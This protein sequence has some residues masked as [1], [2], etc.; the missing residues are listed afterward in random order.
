MGGVEVGEG[1]C[2]EVPTSHG[3]LSPVTSVPMVS[4]WLDC[5]YLYL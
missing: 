5:L 3:Y 2:V 4:H 1:V